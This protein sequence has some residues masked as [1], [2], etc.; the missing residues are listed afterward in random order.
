MVTVLRPWGK[1][2]GR[3][4]YDPAGKIRQVI[5]RIG[6]GIDFNGGFAHDCRLASR[7]RTSELAY[8]GIDVVALVEGYLRTAR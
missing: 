3:F 4:G 7:K 8:V 1:D 2:W 6:M 5:N